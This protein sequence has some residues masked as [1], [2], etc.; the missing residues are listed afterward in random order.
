MMETM[1]KPAGT[2]RGRPRS[3]EADEAILR[4]ALEIAAEVGV[5]RMSMDEVAHRADVGKATIYRRWSS[6]EALV[7]DALKSAMS[8]IGDIDT[9]HLL[10]DLDL[11]FAELVS[12]FEQNP[13]SDVLPHLIE[14]ACHDPA[15]QTSLDDWVRFRRL[16]L[17]RIYERAQD[18]GEIS[19]DA[20]VDVLID[21]TIGPFVY[22][23]LLTREP[24]DADF[25]AR[26]VAIVA[27]GI[28]TTG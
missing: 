1:T 16:P 11:Y 6:K 10:H 23:R 3:V 2:R 20:D 12:R 4:A 28:S 21:A 17:R 24:I 27:P 8:P 19:A 9:G 25:A 5:S 22:R 26:L 7:L 18:R 15:I 13:M 14:A